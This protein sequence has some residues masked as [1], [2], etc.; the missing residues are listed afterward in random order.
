MVHVT[1]LPGSQS[2]KRAGSPWAGRH[3]QQDP[4]LG[5]RERAQ[6]TPDECAHLVAAPDCLSGLTPGPYPRAAPERPSGRLRGW[7][8]P[9]SQVVSSVT[10]LLK[11]A[12]LQQAHKQADGRASCFSGI[13]SQKKDKS[14]IWTFQPRQHPILASVSSLRFLKLF[15]MHSLSGPQRGLRGSRP[16]GCGPRLQ[17]ARPAG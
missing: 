10:G 8:G 6:V 11:S 1:Q 5:Q 15:H 17:G 9:V 2:R 14:M 4:G 13:L 16:S 12:D 7:E 3:S